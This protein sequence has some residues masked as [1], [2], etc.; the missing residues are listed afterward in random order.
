MIVVELNHNSIYLY[1][2][3][4]YNIY[5]NFCFGKNYSPT[6]KSIKC[7]DNLVIYS[8]QLKKVTQCYT[9]SPL[10]CAV[11]MYGSQGERRIFMAKVK[12]VSSKTHT[13]KQ[14]DDYAN[15]HNPNNKA[16]RARVKN[17]MTYKIKLVKNESTFPKKKYAKFEK[18]RGLDAAL[19]W[20]CYSNPF[21]FE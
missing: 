8:I 13:Q 16:Y 17:D 19:D 10:S 15:Q 1:Y 3:K 7:M 9:Y 18:K 2:K 14:L 4:Y 21:D 12:G 5:D 11:L 20:M 6:L